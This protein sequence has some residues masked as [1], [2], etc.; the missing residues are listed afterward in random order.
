MTDD[1]SGAEAAPARGTAYR[2]MHVLEALITAQDGLGVRETSRRTGIDRSAVS[3]LLGQLQELQLATQEAGG[4]FV[5]GPRLYALGAALVARDSLAKAAHPILE[6]VSVTFDETCYLAV[7]EAAG[8]TFR[9]KVECTRPI[10]YVIELGQLAPLHAGGA[11]RAILSG[12]SDH[13]LVQAL[14]GPFERLTDRT[15]TDGAALRARVAEDRERGYAFSLGERV[16]GGSALAAPFFDAAGECRGA[17][18][19]TRP[20]ERHRQ[21]DLEVVAAAVMAAGREL[22]GRLGQLDG[23][24]REDQRRPAGPDGPTQPT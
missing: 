17:V 13:E 5:V 14:R 2:L 22:S 10:R 1:L 11:G 19:F 15:I 6:R 23:A 8:F 20:S 21:S 3:R 18:V 24:G 4:R 9:D 12:L 16:A 7:R